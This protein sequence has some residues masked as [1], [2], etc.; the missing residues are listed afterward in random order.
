MARRFTDYEHIRQALLDRMKKDGQY[1]PKTILHME[2]DTKLTKR[3]IGDTSLY[4]LSAD[5]VKRI[6]RD[7]AKS[8]LAV[9]T[10][11]DYIFAIKQMLKLIGNPAWQAHIQFQ[12]DIRPHV[13]W[14]SPED[15]RKVLESDLVT[16]TQHLV[17]VLAL[18]MGLRK[19][20]IARL[21]V[22][23]INHDGQYITVTGKGRA[24]GKL[25]LVPFHKRFLPALDRYLAVRDNIYLK[26]VFDMPQ[27]LLVWMD[28][29]T[30]T[31]R[32]Y[33]A[34]KGSGLDC[35]IRNA[36]KA[37]GVKFSAHTLRRTFGRLL[38]LSGVPVVTIAKILGHSST[39]QTLEYIGANLD[40]MASAMTKLRLQ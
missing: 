6:A 11:K 16:P 28:R 5:D 34:V 15:A 25:R 24:G 20:E 33:E 18:C 39:E 27:E 7:I 4:D 35:L 40:D 30:S 14:L 32:P 26:T 8:G 1:S 2:W 3:F 12:A 38:W 19:V 22:K 13:D 23:D 37:I 9:A 17:I 10:Q 36:S 31:A 21:K 29:K